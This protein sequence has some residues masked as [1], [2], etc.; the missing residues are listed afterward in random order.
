MRGTEGKQVFHN[1][2]PYW[3]KKNSGQLPLEPR[4]IEEKTEAEFLY[5]ALYLVE[6]LLVRA[7]RER[8]FDERGYDA[9]LVFLHAPCGYRRHAEPYAA[10]DH[11][12]LRVER[13]GV[14]IGCY[15]GV[16]ESILGFVARKAHRR[17]VNEHKMIIGSARDER[18]AFFHEGLGAGAFV[19]EH[20]LLVF[21]KRR[22]QRLLERHCLGGYDVHQRAALYA[23]KYLFIYLFFEL[24]A[25]HYHAGARAAKRFMSGRR[26][27]L[28]E[29]HGARMK[30]CGDKPGYVGNIHHH[31]CACLVRDFAEGLKVYNPRVRARSDDY[32]FRTVLLGQ[33]PHHI[34]VYSV[35]VFSYAV[36]DNLI[37]LTREINQASVGKMSS[38]R[39]VHAHDGVAGL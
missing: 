3:E 27:E 29:R 10:C 24:L 5:L 18:K 31:H 28:R 36:E 7:V 20:L 12:A 33:L 9:H 35:V 1:E 4:L 14:F 32:H 6:F 30:P 11:R 38:V 25:T 26:D 15:A 17:D 23:G 22:L 39:E 21:L 37:K 2:P 13:D 34:H 19:R 8:P 16:K